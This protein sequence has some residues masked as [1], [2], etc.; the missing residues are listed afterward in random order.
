MSVRPGSHRS[1]LPGDRWFPPC[2]AGVVTPIPSTRAISDV[3]RY[4]ACFQLEHSPVTTA[5]LV[6]VDEPRNAAPVVPSLKG[7][8][9][10]QRCCPWFSWS[11]RSETGVN[12]SKGMR[13]RHTT[14]R[15]V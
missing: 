5:V 15:P 6:A 11:H 1:G 10:W 4:P 3:V 12:D 7:S 9:H 8:R 13:D 2:G 14:G